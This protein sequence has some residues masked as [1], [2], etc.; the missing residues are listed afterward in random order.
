MSSTGHRPSASDAGA[1]AELSELSELCELL[2]VRSYRPGRFVLASGR[3]S[4]FFIDCKQA[5]LTARGHVLVGKLMLDALAELP[6]CEAVAGVALGGCPLA[7]AV[8]LTS[9][10]AG[11]PI[12]AI[13]VRKET[14]DHGSRRAVEGDAALRP[15]IPV[16]MLE[17]VVTTGGSTLKAVEILRG[18]G[19]E[20][21]GV[22]AIVDRLEG[23]REALTAAKL[24]FV[25]LYTRH[26]F[27]APP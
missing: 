26:D 21:V 15:G 25:S 5:V 19:A 9:E 14:K 24:P 8:S 6:A 22:V 16:V 12:P 7:S 3:E 11:R 17:D 20:V 10:L 1:R 23:G 13:Y 27:V 2:R 18:V 4:D